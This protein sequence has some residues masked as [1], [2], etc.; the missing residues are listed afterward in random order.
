MKLGKTSM[1]RSARGGISNLETGEGIPKGLSASIVLDLIKGGKMMGLLELKEVMGTK[2]WLL[3]IAGLSLF[4]L[5][6][7]VV[8]VLALTVL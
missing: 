7:I 4:V 1:V 2:T 3:Y 8:F 6:W 5:F